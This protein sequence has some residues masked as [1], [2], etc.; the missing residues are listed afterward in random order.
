MQ[1]D[2]LAMAL[3]WYSAVMQGDYSSMAPISEKTLLRAV[4]TGFTPNAHRPP[5]SPEA[6]AA[7]LDAKSGPALQPRPPH[8][9]I[10]HPDVGK[11]W[12]L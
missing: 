12:A 4:G 9:P 8:I 10:N 1:P 5:A 3:A 7:M 11:V 6:L 2:E